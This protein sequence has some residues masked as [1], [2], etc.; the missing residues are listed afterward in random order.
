MDYTTLMVKGPS[1]STEESLALTS[2][3][4]RSPMSLADRED[5]E[6]ELEYG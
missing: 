2:L 4:P 6:N 3:Y 1:A 5:D